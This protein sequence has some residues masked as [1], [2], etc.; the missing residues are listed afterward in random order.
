MAVMWSKVTTVRKHLLD[1][2]HCHYIECLRH[3]MMLHVLFLQHSIVVVWG[4]QSPLQT[5]VTVEVVLSDCV[6]SYFITLSLH[7]CV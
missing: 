4:L 3:Q 6:A 2:M 5:I 7:R 1:P